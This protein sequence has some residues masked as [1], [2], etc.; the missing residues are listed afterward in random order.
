MYVPLNQTFCFSPKNE[1]DEDFWECNCN[2]QQ[3]AAPTPFYSCHLIFICLFSR[4]SPLVC[5]CGSHYPASKAREKSGKETGQKEWSV[6][7]FVRKQKGLTLPRAR[8]KLLLCLPLNLRRNEILI[9]SLSHNQ[10]E[11]ERIAP[12]KKSEA[13]LELV[14]LLWCWSTRFQNNSRVLQSCRLNW[15]PK[16]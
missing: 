13:K 14:F 15:R 6:V 5:I 9:I 4:R 12:N 1:D 3:T 7:E 16:S 11:N 10:N 2:G 8:V